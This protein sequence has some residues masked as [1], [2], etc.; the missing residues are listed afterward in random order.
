MCVIATG[1]QDRVRLF[2]C[3]QETSSGGLCGAVYL[4]QAFEAFIRTKV[5]R[6]DYDKLPEKVKAKAFDSDWEHSIK[7]SYRGGT[8]AW[9]VDIPGYKP[10]KPGMFG[11]RSTST[12][13]LEPWVFYLEIRLGSQLTEYKSGHVNTIFQPVCSKVVDL[14]RTQVLEVKEETSAD[15]KVNLPP[16]FLMRLDTKNSIVLQAILLV[17]GFGE[18]EFLMKLLNDTFSRIQIQRPTRA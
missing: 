18:N 7:R 17:G 10:K 1:K 5:G 4:D 12:I 16:L 13:M 2:F 3:W 14:V 11:R 6:T 15:P 9:P 8:D